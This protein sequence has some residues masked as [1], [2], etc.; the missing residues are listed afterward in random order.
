MI[1][2]LSPLDSP[3]VGETEKYLQHIPEVL[4]KR[5]RGSRTSL[6]LFWK[7]LLLSTS[8]KIIRWSVFKR[9]I[10]QKRV[11]EVLGPLNHFLCTSSICCG[12]FLGSPTSRL[13]IGNNF[14]IMIGTDWILWQEIGLLIVF[15]RLKHETHVE[16]STVWGLRGHFR[17]RKK[18]FDTFFK[19]SASIVLSGLIWSTD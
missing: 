19:K 16:Y 11:R 7:I 4:R 9:R 12:Y 6:A 10:F 8:T 17:Y 14:R 15:S 1:P 13:S 3:N 2:K 5:F 18:F